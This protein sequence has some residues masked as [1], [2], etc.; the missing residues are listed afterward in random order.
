MPR[1][2]RFL[3]STAIQCSELFHGP[4]QI[5]LHSWF[6]R[7]LRDAVTITS[8]YNQMLGSEAPE[9]SDVIPRIETLS[10]YRTKSLSVSTQDL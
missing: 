4:Q 9:K 6:I 5:D 8:S 10:L 7:R 3:K 1:C 2:R